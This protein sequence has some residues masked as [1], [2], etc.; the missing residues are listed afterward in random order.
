[1]FNDRGHSYI[2]FCMLFNAFNKDWI[3]EVIE[4][5][6]MFVISPERQLVINE[7]FV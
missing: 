5:G 4:K 2:H 3:P 1:M 6:R 7:H